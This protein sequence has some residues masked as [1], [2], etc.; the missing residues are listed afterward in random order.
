MALTRLIY[1]STSLLEPATADADTGVIVAQCRRNNPGL[2]IT[3]ALLTTGGQFV[4]VLEGDAQVLGRL[5]I[6]L[7]ADPRHGNIMVMDHAP[8]AQRRFD[9]WAMAYSGEA[10]FVGTRVARLLDEKNP[11]GQRRAARWLI[12]L[13]QEFAAS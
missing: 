13:M 3:G 1:T 12:D 4:Q 6:T 7:R 11:S 10:Q 9:S 8:V 5:M 2:A